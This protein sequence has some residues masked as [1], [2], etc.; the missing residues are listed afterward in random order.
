MPVIKNDAPNPANQAEKRVT[1]ATRIP[2]SVPQTRLSIPD[3]PGYH[4]H[5]MLGKNVPR[6]LQ[7]GYQFVDQEEVAVVNQDLAGDPS[8]GSGTDLGSRVSVTAGGE[9][10]HAGQ[11]ERLYLMKLPMEFWEADQAILAERNEAIA[12]RIRGGHPDTGGDQSN[13][14]LKTGQQLFVPRSQRTKT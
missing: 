2:M 7:A 5:W 3:L 1:A 4:L 9:L 14:Y 13:R 10:D 11:P 6:A 8:E 12:A